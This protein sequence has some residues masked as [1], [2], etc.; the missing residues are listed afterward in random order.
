ML[1]LF[2]LL[3]LMALCRVVM[4]VA[5]AKGHNGCLF[6]LVFLPFGVGGLFGGGGAA[7]VISVITSGDDQPNVLVVLVGGLVGMGV[8]LVIALLILKL[9]PPHRPAK[10]A[11]SVE[12]AEP[13]GW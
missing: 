10:R 8:G 9:I 13:E 6:G 12:D 2:E 11:A 7:G 1:F 3:T 5:R 4:L